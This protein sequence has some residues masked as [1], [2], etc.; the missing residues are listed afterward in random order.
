[1]RQKWLPSPTL[2]VVKYLQVA[3]QDR[4]KYS[5]LVKSVPHQ[6]AR[7]TPDIVSVLAEAIQDTRTDVKKPPVIPSPRLPR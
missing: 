7:L 2:V 3:G 6:I 1:M 4:L 5:T